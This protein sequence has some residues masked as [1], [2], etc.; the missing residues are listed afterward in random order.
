[1][2]PGKA[3]RVGFGDA[4]RVIP[5]PKYLQPVARI[6][7]AR[8]VGVIR[9]A[10]AGSPDRLGADV[11]SAVEVLRAAL[12]RCARVTRGGLGLV[13]RA[14]KAGPL[15]SARP[16]VEYL[17]RCLQVGELFALLLG[18]LHRLLSLDPT[19][20]AFP[21]ALAEAQ[22]ACRRLTRHL[23]GNFAFDTVCPVGGDQ[24]SWLRARRMIRCLLLQMRERQ[25]PETDPAPGRG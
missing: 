20:E 11:P 10:A 25:R 13:R 4:P 1:M 12:A 3:S 22:A 24:A 2:A 19:L 18:S 16:D 9:E 15:P 17:A 23:D 14:L 21:K 8:A 7:I 5:L 6:R